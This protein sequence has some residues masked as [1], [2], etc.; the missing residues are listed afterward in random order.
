VEEDFCSHD[1]GS[2]EMDRVLVV[3]GHPKKNAFGHDHG[4]IL[5]VDPDSNTARSAV[6]YITPPSARPDE[7]PS[8]LFKAATLSG[9]RLYVCTQTE[10]LI[11]DFPKFEQVGYF[12]LTCFND[13][14]HVRPTG[15]GTLLVANTGLD[16]VL[17][18]GLEGQVIR[19]WD[20]LGGDSWERFSRDV[21]YRKIASTKPHQAHPNYVFLIGEEPWVTRFEQ[22]DAI[23]L[24][25]RARRI[26]IGIERPHDGIV[27]G[28]SI[29]FTTVDVVV[30]PKSDFRES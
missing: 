29:Y 6:Q 7:N 15:S 18:M 21:D 20:V 10:V 8:I 22:R 4:L 25:D 16:M 9:D 12:S 3:G 1:P 24:I 23:S 11:Y 28:D 17:E 27:A 30:Q 19:E 14:H 26:D 13:V 5:E 2:I